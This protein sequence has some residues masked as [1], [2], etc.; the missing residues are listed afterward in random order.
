MG[1]HGRGTQLGS[2]MGLRV[3]HLGTE[4]PAPHCCVHSGKRGMGQGASSP[5]YL[6]IE[7]GLGWIRAV[8]C[9]LETSH[10]AALSPGSSVA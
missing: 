4:R 2:R 8:C 6:C 3:A 10:P 5:Q 1:M 7:W 9:R